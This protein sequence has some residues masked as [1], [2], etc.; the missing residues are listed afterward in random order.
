LLVGKQ[1]GI[2]GGGGLQRFDVGKAQL[3]A[4]ASNCSSSCFTWS[5]PIW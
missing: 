1:L 5:M 2:V 4:I 3:L